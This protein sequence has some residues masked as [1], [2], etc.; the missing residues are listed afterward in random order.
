MRRERGCERRALCSAGAAEP[1]LKVLNG[2]SCRRVGADLLTVD[3]AEVAFA[4]CKEL[5]DLDNE[6]AQLSAVHIGLHRA[7]SGALEAWDGGE[8]YTHLPSLWIGQD[9]P[10]S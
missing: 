4:A 7:S 5:A 8:V 2:E 10:A 1:N 9:T 6:H 3:S